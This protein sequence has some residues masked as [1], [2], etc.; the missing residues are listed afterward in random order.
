M[1]LLRTLLVTVLAGL[2]AT[3][4]AKP[5]IHADLRA[6][7]AAAAARINGGLSPPGDVGPSGEASGIKIITFSDSR[8]SDSLITADGTRVVIQRAEQEGFQTP[9]DEESFVV[10]GM[11]VLGTAHSERGLTFYEVAL[12]EHMAPEFSPWGAFQ[13]MQYVMGFKDTPSK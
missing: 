4:D 5:S 8:A 12:C 7:Q 13:I 6:R 11:G 2:H 9:I 1:F 10:D 3:A